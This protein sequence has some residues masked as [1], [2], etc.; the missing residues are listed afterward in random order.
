MSGQ[1]TTCRF[2]SW[3]TG[4]VKRLKDLRARVITRVVQE[5]QAPDAKE[6]AVENG[7]EETCGCLNIFHFTLLKKLCK[8]ISKVLLD[9]PRFD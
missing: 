8:R 6:V 7:A 3:A 4:Q 9:T 2:A 5:V 1:E